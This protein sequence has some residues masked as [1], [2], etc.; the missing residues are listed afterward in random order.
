MH[1]LLPSQNSSNAPS[2]FAVIH[3]FTLN[4]TYPVSTLVTADSMSRSPAHPRASVPRMILQ[5]ILRCFRRLNIPLPTNIPTSPSHLISPLK[6]GVAAALT[7]FDRSLSP[8]DTLARIA[9]HEWSVANT[10][11]LVFLGTVASLSWWIMTAPGF[12]IKLVIPIAYGLAVLIPATNQFFWPAAPVLT[13]VI[14][15][16]AARF[17]PSAHRP[18]IHVALL[19]ALESVLYGANISD[20]QTRFT[21]PVLDI[22]AWLPYGVLHFTIPAVVAFLLWALGPRGAIQYW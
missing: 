16:F 19:P 3:L 22:L 4:T 2:N 10:L 15:F 18:T 6:H 1:K 20:L 17:I 13:W 21:H 14:T 12:P 5:P 11:P 8:A 7:R 9:Q